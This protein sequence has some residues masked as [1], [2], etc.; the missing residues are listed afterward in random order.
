MRTCTWVGDDGVGR[1]V[2]TEGRPASARKS[3]RWRAAA[4]ASSTSAQHR[5]RHSPNPKKA[6]R[7][8]PRRAAAPLQRLERAAVGARPVVRQ[9]LGAHHRLPAV[10]LVG[11]AQHEVDAGVQA[12]PRV[13]ALR[14]RYQAASTPAKTA[15]RICD[16]S[17]GGAGRDDRARAASPRGARRRRGRGAPPRWWRRCRGRALR[18]P[19]GV[20]QGCRRGRLYMLARRKGEE[21]GT[22]G[23]GDARRVA[24]SGAKLGE[25]GCEKSVE[26]VHRRHRRVRLE[27]ARTELT[28]ALFRG[29]PMYQGSRVPSFTDPAAAPRPRSAVP[30]SAGGRGL[31]S[32]RPAPRLCARHPRG[33]ASLALNRPSALHSAEN[34]PRSAMPRRVG[35]APSAAAAATAAPT[36]PTAATASPRDAALGIVV[37]TAVQQ[38][39][40]FLERGNGEPSRWNARC[41]SSS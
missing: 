22:L 14:L 41:A 31:A 4:R 40:E 26:E 33:G 15:K 27:Q 25:A 30:G 6:G 3:P 28:P 29:R 1:W 37:Q 16:A 36:A 24:R 35:A 17:T 13:A 12:R 21:L 34:R 18:P 2:V 7:S 11:P 10:A 23:A 19:G 39:C 9:E 8:A 32:G 20:A 5:G 38:L